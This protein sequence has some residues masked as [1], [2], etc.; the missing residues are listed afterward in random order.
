MRDTPEGLGLEKDVDNESISYKVD[1]PGDEK[2]DP[3]H[4]G[5][6]RVLQQVSNFIIS[7]CTL[8]D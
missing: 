1:Y 8:Y 6:Q 2:D 3:K 5:H 4:V 7:I